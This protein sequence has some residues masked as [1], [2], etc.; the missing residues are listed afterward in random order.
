VKLCC[1]VQR[2]NGAS[3]LFCAKAASAELKL[4]AL[5]VTQARRAV[6]IKR[7]RRAKTSATCIREG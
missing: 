7:T 6:A 4:P 5:L 3:Y 1:P 2:E